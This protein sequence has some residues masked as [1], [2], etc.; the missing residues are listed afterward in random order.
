MIFI[1]LKKNA[2]II[3]IIILLDWSDFFSMPVT[4]NIKIWP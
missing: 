4:N 1:E 3:I 2:S